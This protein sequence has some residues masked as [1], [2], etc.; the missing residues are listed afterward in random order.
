MIP[1]TLDEIFGDINR[2]Q[3]ISTEGVSN[4]EATPYSFSVERLPKPNKITANL[5]NNVTFL[6]SHQKKH[7]QR[8]KSN[9]DGVT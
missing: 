8:Q 3:A 9:V 7:Q 4:T 6:K 2:F 5:I 1:R